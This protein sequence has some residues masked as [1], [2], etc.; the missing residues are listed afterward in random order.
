MIDPALLERI[1][2]AL[3]A[4]DRITREEV[5][6]DVYF[7]YRDLAMA[8]LTE[9]FP[10]RV[11]G[12]VFGFWFNGVWQPVLAGVTVEAVDPYHVTFH[13]PKP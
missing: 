4:N 10:E 11:E 12:E 8:A 6:A 7:H 2:N 3:M 9:L 5:S 13:Y 1:V